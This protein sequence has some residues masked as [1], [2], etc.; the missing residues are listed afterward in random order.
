MKYGYIHLVNQ[1]TKPQQA[2]TITLFWSGVIAVIFTSILIVSLLHTPEYYPDTNISEALVFLAL[3]DL[4]FWLPF[5]IL[6]KKWK[7]KW[8][9]LNF[10]DGTF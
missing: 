5:Y 2:V 1:G 8:D 10:A 6:Y 7:L 3:I 4:I 9:W